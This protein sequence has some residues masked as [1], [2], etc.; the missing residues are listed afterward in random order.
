[1]FVIAGVLITGG[2]GNSLTKAELFNPLS[3]RS[4]LLPPLSLGRDYHTSCRNLQCGGWESD[5]TTRSCRHINDSSI[6]ITLRQKRYRHLCWS[7]PGDQTDVLLLGGWGS[8]RT[9]ERISG[10]S[11]SANFTLPYKTRYKSC[12]TINNKTYN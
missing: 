5:T 2:E 10:S 7:L 4:C 11:S 3:N 8:S 6:T 9:T 1:M 12:S